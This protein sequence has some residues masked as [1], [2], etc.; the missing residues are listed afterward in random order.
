MSKFEQH[1]IGRFVE[2]FF[3]SRG[4]LPGKLVVDLPAGEGRMSRTLRDLGATVEPYDLYPE[5]FKVEGMTCRFADLEQELPIPS[6]HADYVVFQEG[7]EHLPDQLR[8][9]REFNRILKEGG[10]LVLTTPNPSC[11]RAR[12]CHFLIEGYLFNQLPINEANAIRFL[13]NSKGR[14]YFGHVFLISA[15]R[16]RILARIAGFRIAGIHP[17]RYSKSSVLLGVTYPVLFLFNWFAYQKTRRRYRRLEASWLRQTLREVMALNL[18][19]RIL[20]AK[21]LFFE[22]EKICE[23][24]EAGA[25]FVDRTKQ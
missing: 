7:L 24:H 10:R 15:Q 1:E 2:E 19:P 9:L 6:R 3:R 11:L 25:A 14:Y 8:A 17:N 4:G 20:F 12:L 5:F 16:L 22:L 18:N 23:P 21:K 13:D